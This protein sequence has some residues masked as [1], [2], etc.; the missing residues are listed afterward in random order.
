MAPNILYKSKTLETGKYVRTYHQFTKN[1]GFKPFD[2]QSDEN[3]EF[4]YI[5]DGTFLLNLHIILKLDLLDCFSITE[6]LS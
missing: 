4:N 1:I 5:F 6:M 2:L 3:G